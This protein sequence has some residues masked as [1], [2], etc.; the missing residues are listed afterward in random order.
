MKCSRLLL[1]A[2][3][4]VY[5]SVSLVQYKRKNA[6]CVEPIIINR[7]T[8]SFN[9]LCIRERVYTFRLLASIDTRVCKL[10]FCR[11]LQSQPLE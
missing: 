5:S 6:A 10:Y 11:P 2:S 3:G 9:F 8:S 7:V 4:V 1:F